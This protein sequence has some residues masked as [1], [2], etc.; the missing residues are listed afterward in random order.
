M[1]EHQRQDA[2]QIGL[3]RKSLEATVI[4]ACR[5]C[6]APGTYVA[7]ESIKIG[8]PGCYVT[9]NDPLK[10]Q[11]VGKICPNCM[12]PRAASLVENHGE[13]SA[14]LPRWLWRTVLGF[15]WIILKAVHFKRRISA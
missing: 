4:R 11:P 5:F 6:Q 8:W 14:S 13:L 15:K 3:T 1:A 7:H 2:A 10:G 12:R 9:D